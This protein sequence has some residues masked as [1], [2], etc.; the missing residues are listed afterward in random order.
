MGSVKGTFRK[1]RFKPYKKLA[2]KKPISLGDA[3][4]IVTVFMRRALIQQK[5]MGFMGLTD[6]SLA[7]RQ[8][9]C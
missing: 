2:V 3:A 6:L 8:Y 9:Y 1:R 7:A 5:S 4:R